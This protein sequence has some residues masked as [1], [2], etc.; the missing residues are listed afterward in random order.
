[1]IDGVGS[2]HTHVARFYC[3]S[4]AQCESQCQAFIDTVF[5]LKLFSAGA[6]A[7]AC[8]RIGEK[9]LFDVVVSSSRRR[10]RT[11]VK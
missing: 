4:P 8:L 7:P 11:L 2:G 9:A 5:F 3:P 1:M 6:V 10:E